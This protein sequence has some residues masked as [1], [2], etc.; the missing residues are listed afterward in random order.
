[1]SKR[2]VVVTG[3]VALLAVLAVLAVGLANGITLF[4]GRLTSHCKAFID[5]QPEPRLTYPGG[6]LIFYSSGEGTKTLDEVDGPSSL[7][8]ID[9]PAPQSAVDAWY[10]S[11]LQAHGWSL[12]ARYQYPQEIWER[13]KGKTDNAPSVS[14]EYSS[15]RGDQGFDASYPA[16]PSKKG[17]TAVKLWYKVHLHSYVSTLCS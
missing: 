5:S 17:I 3:V 1:M 4:G 6:T 12:V 16:D 8:Y 13:V 11:W 14:L 9:V 15:A 10:R 7:A 2:W